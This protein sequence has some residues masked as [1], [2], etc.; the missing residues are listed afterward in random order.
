MVHQHFQ[1]H[2]LTYRALPEN[3]TVQDLDMEL[4]IPVPKG[5]RPLD[6]TRLPGLTSK[7]NAEGFDRQKSVQVLKSTSNGQVLYYLLNGQHR[8]AAWKMVLK[9]KNQ[10]T[11]LKIPCFVFEQINRLEQDNISQNRVDNYQNTM[12]FREFVISFF[13]RLDIYVDPV[14][15]GGLG[16][17][18]Q[19]FIRGYKDDRSWIADCIRSYLD[20]TRKPNQDLA[21]E[22]KKEKSPAFVSRL[23]KP[24]KFPTDPSS[25]LDPPVYLSDAWIAARKLV[26]DVF[27]LW[28][29]LVELKLGLLFQKIGL[30]RGQKGGIT[31]SAFTFFFDRVLMIHQRESTKFVRLHGTSPPTDSTVKATAAAYK[32]AKIAMD[33]VIETELVHLRAQV[34]YF[35]EVS[36]ALLQCIDLKREGSSAA[37]WPVQT[38]LTVQNHLILRARP[39]PEQASL[40]GRYSTYYGSATQPVLLALSNGFGSTQSQK[41]LKAKWTTLVNY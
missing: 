19:E 4:L 33:S 38:L 30:G 24:F 6:E 5:L 23:T 2:F 16:F 27:A 21:D 22:E 15:E 11:P 1:Y 20:Y 8:V 28:P 25:L 26:R 7:M 10:P 9:A 12:N 3:Y 37:T 29:S 31:L 13:N 34:I 17:N 35:T 39:F 18:E 40:W 41:A 32:R 36:S 14:Q